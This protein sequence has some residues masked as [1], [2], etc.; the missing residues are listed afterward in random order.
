MSGMSSSSSL[1]TAVAGLASQLQSVIF[2]LFRHG[3]YRTVCA[4]EPLFSAGKRQREEVT[5]ELGGDVSTRNG[6]EDAQERCETF[7]GAHLGKATAT[8]SCS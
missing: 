7:M 5:R 4:P 3:M 6:T 8:I 2:T 1:S